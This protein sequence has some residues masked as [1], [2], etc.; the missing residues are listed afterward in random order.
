MEGA[1][2]QNYTDEQKRVMLPKQFRAF[3]TLYREAVE[4]QL[5][6]YASATTEELGDY[7]LYIKGQYKA[8]S[9]SDRKLANSMWK[10]NRGY[11]SKSKDSV[12]ETQDMSI[13]DAIDYVKNSEDFT[14]EEK[15]IYETNLYR[16]IVDEVSLLRRRIN[17]KTKAEA[18]VLAAD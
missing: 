10:D 7:Q 15:K 13:D 4:D 6:R 17:K 1:E 18:K 3:E 2:Y 12:F 11:Y 8:M 14:D 5:K 9:D 16:L